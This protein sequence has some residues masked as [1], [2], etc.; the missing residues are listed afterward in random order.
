VRHGS[1]VA[2]V[3]DEKGMALDV[4]FAKVSVG[5]HKAAIAIFRKEESAGSNPAVKAYATQYLPMLQTHLK[6]AEHA[7][8]KLGVTPTK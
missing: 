3:E 6:L 4:A 7:E 2:Q 1:L 8:S 5:G